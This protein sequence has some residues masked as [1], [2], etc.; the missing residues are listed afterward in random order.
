MMTEAVNTTNNLEGFVKSLPSQNTKTKFR[1]APQ[2]VFRGFFRR[3]LGSGSVTLG[4]AFGRPSRP[5]TKLRQCLGRLLTNAPLWKTQSRSMQLLGG[6]HSFKQ[7]TTVAPVAGLGG[8]L[9]NLG[10]DLGRTL[11]DLGRQWQQLVACL[12]LERK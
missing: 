2:S 12:V 3:D 11:V 8:P 5:Q 1:T 6:F 10:G 4:R 9:G 7:M